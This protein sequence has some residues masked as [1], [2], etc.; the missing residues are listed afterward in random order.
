M[1]TVMMMAVAALL[2]GLVQG[3]TGFGAGIVIMTLIPYIFPL[4][5]AAAMTGMISIVLT[6]S[7]AWKYREHMRPQLIILPTVFYL[8]TSTLAVNLATVMDMTVLKIIY[9]L[10]LIALSL[11]FLF[12]KGASVPDNT[13][14]IILCGALS[15]LCDGFFSAGGPFMVLLFMAATSSEDEY[16]AN[17]QTV[18]FIVALYNTALRI[19]K[20]IITPALVAPTLIGVAVMLV[21]LGLAGKVRTKVSADTVRLITYIVIG[22][23]GVIT[24]VTT[25]F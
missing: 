23:S 19:F 17:L 16:M 1:T 4:T 5:S 10:F 8:I 21:G 22:V 15:G 7:M 2:G 3:V 9:A 25:V 14:S 12:V 11:Y 13:L 24:L 6:G 18:F 20:G